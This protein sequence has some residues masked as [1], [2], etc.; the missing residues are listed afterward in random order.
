MLRNLHIRN[1]A[2][3]RE[4]DVDFTDGL[5]ILTGET[6]AGKSIIIDSIGLALGGRSQRDLVRSGQTGL[7]ELVFETD[8]PGVLESVRA[9]DVEP[10][11]GVILISRK[12]QDGRSTIRVN[13]ETRTAAEV[14]RLASFLI[15]IHGQ[16][17]HQKLLAS[18]VQLDL[19]DRYGKKTIAPLK[20]QTATDYAEYAAIKKQ[21]G[22]SP[23]SAEERARRASFLEFEIGEIDDAALKPGEDEEIEKTYR[24]LLNAK[25]IADAADEVHELTGYDE[26]TAAGELIGRALRRMTQVAEYDERLGQ[27]LSQLSDIDGLLN[28]FNRD[29]SEYADGLSFEAESFADTEE[30]LNTINHLKQ[31]YGDS[32]EEI[33]ASRD[34]KAKELEELQDYEE[35]R[36]QLE[37][38]LGEAERRLRISCD[39][40][41]AERRKYAEIF[42]EE[43]IRQLKELNFARAD[44]GIDFK[45]A[46]RYSANGADAIEFTIAT[47]PGEPRRCLRNVVS[48]GELSRIMLAI[49]TIFADADAVGT[50]IFDEIDTG[51]SGR[52]A[53]RAAEKMAAIARRQQ[54]LCITHLPQIAAMADA[55]YGITKDVSETAAITK[56]ESLSDEESVEEIARLIGGAEI[57]ENTLKSAA[58][59]K[60]M[61]RQYK[62]N[63]L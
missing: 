59:M 46:G 14:R 48:G 63:A 50:V 61:C 4:V 2:L 7:A 51:I 53:Q 44:F 32:I 28:D 54:V 52:T 1:L 49:R 62:K 15:D 47:N 58:E 21:L 39:A 6:G 10:E 38:K 34:A 35:R 11:N 60:E 23:M 18:D 19:L 12:I 30:R 13:G 26:Q 17:E 41:S 27:L 22:G 57:T 8:D 31:K 55:H 37:K 43:V 40:L 9:M 56:I 33:L 29:L 36:A 45:D 20:K 5:N 24:R 42:S 16:S 3:I 25:K